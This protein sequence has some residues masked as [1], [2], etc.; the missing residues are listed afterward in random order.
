MNDIEQLRFR[1]AVDDGLIEDLDGR[2]RKARWPEVPEGSPWEFGTSQPYLRGVIDYWIHDFDWKK[3]EDGLNA[4]SHYRIPVDGRN[5]HCVV[6][7]GTGDNPVPLILFHGWPGC[8]TEYL[9]VAQRLTRAASIGKGA[10]VIVVSLPGAGFSESSGRPIGPRDVGGIWHRILTEQL[11]ISRYALH[12]GDWGA[13]V[14]S[15]M[16]VDFP[17]SVLGIHLTSPILQPDA[18]ALDPPLSEDEAAFLAARNARGPWEFGYQVVQ[19]TK[20]LTLSYGLTDSP[21]GLAAWL[22]EKF[23]GWSASKGKDEY[24]PFDLNDLLTIV[25]LHWVAGPG[26]AMWMYRSIIDG[27]GLRVPADTRVS[28]PTWLCRF[29]DDISPQSPES[30][31][32]R[33]YDVVHRTEVAYGSHFPG[34]DATEPLVEDLLKFV[35]SVS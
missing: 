34:L 11:G 7:R 32:E 5:H 14:S 29:G 9:P 16:A 33:V 23:H 26:P 27:T 21:L 28:V 22:L 31:Q 12:G 4:F 17:A 18:A 10:T 2:L 6:E 13:A 8:F 15:W 20:P 30:W 3:M 24:P 35:R 1:I 25:T 19:G